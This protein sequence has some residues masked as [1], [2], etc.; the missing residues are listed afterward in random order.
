MCVVIIV[1][2]AYFILKIGIYFA[3]DKIPAGDMNV[4]GC[5][6]KIIKITQIMRSTIIIYLKK[7]Y[8]Y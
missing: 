6:K 7:N 1:G 4:K 3:K 2:N 5:V 8:S